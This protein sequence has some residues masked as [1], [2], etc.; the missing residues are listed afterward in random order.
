MLLHDEFS[1]FDVSLSSPQPLQSTIFQL[2]MIVGVPKHL[3]LENWSRQLQQG[4][5]ASGFSAEILSVPIPDSFND[6]VRFL[7]SGACHVFT[8]PL[9]QIPVSRPDEVAITCLSERKSANY[10]LVI[11]PESLD[12]MRLAGLPLHAH[13]AVRTS[14]QRIQLLEIRPDLQIQVEPH[15]LPGNSETL[16]SANSDAIL[17]PYYQIENQPVSEKYVVKVLNPKEIIPLTGQGTLA[18]VTLSADQKIRALFSKFHHPEVAHCTNIERGLQRLFYT[19]GQT[20]I[21]AFCE[22]D[23]HRRYNFYAV[24]W[25]PEIGLKKVQI[26]STSKS[27]LIEKAYSELR[28]TPS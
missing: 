22:F 24:S 4:L 25:K 8:L 6:A 10:A 26:S 28:D 17:V 1:I 14:L 13:V 27:G 21:A 19:A 16:L 7:K 11:R 23:V 2:Q 20:E 12:P 18:V 5:H 15:L 9:E 3:Y